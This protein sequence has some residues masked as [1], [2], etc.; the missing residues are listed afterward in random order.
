MPKIFKDKWVEKFK[1]IYIKLVKTKIENKTEKKRKKVV[2]KC[3]KHFHK[4]FFKT[5]TLK[6]MLEVSF[7]IYQKVIPTIFF[8]TFFK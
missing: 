4:A 8:N 7:V 6:L 1:T 2:I 3:K 5:L